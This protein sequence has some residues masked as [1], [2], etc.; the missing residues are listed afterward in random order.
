MSESEKAIKNVYS[1]TTTASPGVLFGIGNPLL[2]ISV[3]FSDNAI[4]EKYQ[5][6]PNDQILAEEKHQPLYPELESQP[7]V[8][9]LPGGAAQNTCRAVQWCL[10]NQPEATSATIYTGSVGNDDTHTKLKECAEASGLVVDYYFNNKGLPTGT[11]GCVVTGTN[12]SLVANLAAANAYSKDAIDQVWGSVETA[13]YFYSS[14]FFLTTDGGPTAVEKIGK[15]AADNGKTTI[16]NLSAPF[17]PPFFKAQLEMSIKY[18][19][20][21]FGNETEA[22]VWAENNGLED[23]KDDLAAI[24]LAIS[25]QPKYGSKPRMVILT[26]GCNPTVICQN[27][28]VEEFPI[29]KLDQS[30]IVDSNG[31]GDAFVAGFL[32]GLV[33]GKSINDCVSC[34]NFVA[35]SIL[36]MPGCTFPEGHKYTM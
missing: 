19:D 8:Q 31:A 6:K 20:I 18:A 12:R 4:L 33:Y 27:D 5:L 21:V 30:L 14:G 26:H 34:A 16:M 35:R 17:I 15:Y 29:E 7:N 11:C 2:D 3:E 22:G 10:Q 28:N 32:C 24:A 23:K 1:T 9:Y 13:K 25:K 36:M